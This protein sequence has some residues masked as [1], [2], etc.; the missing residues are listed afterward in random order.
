AR[1][2]NVCNDFESAQ[3]EEIVLLCK[4]ALSNTKIERC[5]FDCLQA[6]LTD[7]ILIGRKPDS[8]E[9][10]SIFELVLH[11]QEGRYPGLRMDVTISRVRSTENRVIVSS[12]VSLYCEYFI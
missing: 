1:I 9:M 8:K 10:R 4:P 3:H 2:A 12:A 11:E 5:Q 7:P 6:K